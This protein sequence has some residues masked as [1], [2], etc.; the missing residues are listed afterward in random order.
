MDW[1]SKTVLVTGAGSG[2]GR[3]LCVTLASK[4]CKVTAVDV[5]VDGAE[6]T[7][8]LMKAQGGSG[9]AVQCDVQDDAAQR[10]AFSRHMQ[11]WNSLDVAVLNAG[12]MEK[13]DFVKSEETAWQ[14]TLDI[15]LRAV[16]VGA[17]LATQIM[18]KQGSKIQAKGSILLV[19][20]AGGLFPMPPSPVYA[21][22]KAGLVH[23][24]RSA[25][26][27]LAKAGISLYCLCPQFVDTPL[28]ANVKR[29]GQSMPEMGSQLLRP[30]RVAEASLLLLEDE[31]AHGKVLMV[32]ASGRLYEWVAPKGNLKK[33]YA[34][35]TPG[36][37]QSSS[38]AHAELARWASSGV[39][40]QRRK[41]QVHRLSS[42]F[43]AATRIVSEPLPAP[44]ALPPGHILVRRAYAG[45]NA[46]DINYTAGRYFGSAEV[47]AKRL[48]FDAGFESVGAVAAVG[49][50][51][52]RFS[53]GQPVAELA[54]GAFSEW[55]VVPAKHALA[56]PMLAPEIVALLT[57]GLTAS[58]GLQEAGRLRSGETVLV[59]AAAG[60]VGQFVVQL[61]K[62][63]GSTVI[64][65]CGSEDKAR[66]L[67]RLGADR[68][69]NYRQESL[70]EVLRKEYPKGIDVIWESVGG[71]MFRTCTKA[72]GQGG[73][74]I[75]IGMM[76]QYADGWG[77]SEVAPGLPE[78]LL[79]K[80]ATVV[81][82]FL[83]HY[84]HLYKSHLQRLV[85]AWQSGR[86][87]VAMDGHGFRGLE[88]VAAAQDCLHSGQSVGKLYVQLASDLPAR[89][90]SRM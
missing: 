85:A 82:F 14:T 57:S 6:E 77:A 24:T 20:S 37:Q 31:S 52:H 44:S 4:G 54:Y 16:L 60:G 69:V 8:R 40:A 84:A 76:S 11:A 51:V 67:R 49:P 72:L 68:I 47:A 55:A 59:T 89:A 64:A 7:V 90:R 25:S 53:V 74:L 63:A 71:D 50:D 46:S 5:N 75:V 13:G 36:A 45:I 10:A 30:Q 43:R 33:A 1:T 41:L 3:A 32:H 29:L 27:R 28:V 73:R 23:F 19:A 15:N 42:D 17:H 83:L 88:G 86:L 21:A 2:I 35:S 79:W 56:V 80:S 66:L 34:G 62:Q 70:K 58:I 22:S 87:H 65:T 26:G 38:G 18:R 39:P 12:I 78:L 61:A 81:G 9:I 48:P